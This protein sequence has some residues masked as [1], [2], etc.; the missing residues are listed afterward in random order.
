MPLSRREGLAV[1]LLPKM[2]GICVC[3]VWFRSHSGLGSCGELGN[4]GGLGSCGRLGS[5]GGLEDCGGLEGHSG[6]DGCDSR[7]NCSLVS[8]RKNKYAQNSQICTCSYKKDY[9]LDMIVR[10]LLH[11]TITMTDFYV[12]DTNLRCMW[13]ENK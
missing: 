5:C 3:E 11:S 6:L 12:H 10:R 13:Y 1:P 8:Y 7:E 9:I 2:W 4:H